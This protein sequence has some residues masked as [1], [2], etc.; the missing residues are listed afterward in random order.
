MGSPLDDLVDILDLERLEVD[1]FRGVSL[2]E[3]RVRVFGGQV[4]AQSLIAAARTVDA[5]IPVHSLHAYFLR[6]GDPETPIV[7]DVDRIR[8][9]RSFTTRRVV[10][11]QQGKAIFNMAASY[12]VVEDGPEHSDPMPD[13]PGPEALRPTGRPPWIRMAVNR[14]LPDLD[15]ERP[16]EMRYVGDRR[17][18]AQPADADQDLWLRAVGTLPDDPSLHTAVLAYASD[19]MLLSTAAMPHAGEHVRYMTASLDHVMWFHR[20]CRA[21]EWLLYHCH[22]PAAA[23]AR[24]LSTGAIFR[25]DGVQC[26]TIAQEGLLRPVG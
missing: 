25:R 5:E 12:Q 14:S 7:F 2:E 17:E 23:R 15:R 9:G 21:D 26:V 4:L 8:D 6:P 20:P 24:G 13:V 16:I 22:S 1:L 19:Y 3:G 10:A 18:R 11:I